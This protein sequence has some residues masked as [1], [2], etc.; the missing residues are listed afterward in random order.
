MGPRQPKDMISLFIHY[1]RILNSILDSVV[2]GL[3]KHKAS[4]WCAHL[5]HK[6][7]SAI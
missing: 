3:L 2:K 7:P 6:E 4:S 5:E 1:E